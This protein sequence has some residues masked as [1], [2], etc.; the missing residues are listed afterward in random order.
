MTAAKERNIRDQ[1]QKRAC[2]SSKQ[3]V[4][5][6]VLGTHKHSTISKTKGKLE[7]SYL[8]VYGSKSFTCS[9]ING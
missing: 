4:T 7:V 1:D 8:E 6:V 3:S 2:P 5:V 9:H